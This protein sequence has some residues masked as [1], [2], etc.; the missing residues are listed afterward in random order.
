MASHYLDGRSFGQTLVSL[1]GLMMEAGLER[2][3][4]VVHS[5][6]SLPMLLDILAALIEEEKLG[7]SEEAR[8]FQARLLTDYLE[9]FNR[10]FAEAVNGVEFAEFYQACCRLLCGYL[11]LEKSL[12]NV[13]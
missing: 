13:P 9:P 8:M 11:D 10:K 7:N 2:E 4:G 6:D 3:E 5:E 12:I 1:R